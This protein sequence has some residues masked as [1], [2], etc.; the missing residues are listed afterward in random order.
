MTAES[1]LMGVP[2]I[3]Y[4]AV[5]NII[6]NFLVKKGL[7]KRETNPKKI[8]NYIKRIFESPNNTHQKRAQKIVKQM[9]DPIQTLVKVMK[10]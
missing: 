8:S 2:T 4:D 1:A 3:S 9:D 6:E 5:P 10:D 7:V